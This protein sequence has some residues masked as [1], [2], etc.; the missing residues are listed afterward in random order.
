MHYLVATATASLAAAVAVARSSLRSIRI[1][2]E[3][4]DETEITAVQI[5]GTTLI[6]IRRRCAARNPPEEFENNGT[7]QHDLR[8]GE[9][10]LLRTRAWELYVPDAILSNAEIC[11]GISASPCR[12]EYTIG[13][14]DQRFEISFE[15]FALSLREVAPPRAWLQETGAPLH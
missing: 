10:M 8:N 11:V 7:T 5:F 15:R 3:W 1:S 2:A 4:T 14:V 13:S 12:Y 6:H 9:Q